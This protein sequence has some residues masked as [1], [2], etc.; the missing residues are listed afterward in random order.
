MINIVKVDKLLREI[1]NLYKNDKIESD[2]DFVIIEMP[3]TSA[4]YTIDKNKK[5]HWNHWIIRVD[6]VKPA[7]G[8]GKEELIYSR[9]VDREE[10]TKKDLI[11]EIM[12]LTPSKK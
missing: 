11:S 1:E 10:I 5:I 8:K 4:S 9:D 2:M 6:I 7:K 12:A 3:N